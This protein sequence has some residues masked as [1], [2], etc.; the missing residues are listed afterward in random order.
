MDLFTHE[1]E[2]RS[3]PLFKKLATTKI[4]VCGCGAIGS[5][6]IDNL[7]RQGFKQI[8]VIDH[9]RIE[10]HN[11]GTQIWDFRETGKLKTETMKTRAY[12]STK[13]IV[14]SIPRKLTMDNTTKLLKD[15][16]IIIDTFDN[17][18]SRGLLYNY[19]KETN[20]NCLHTGLFQDY[21]EI[22]WNETYIVPK[23][24]K[25]MDVCEYPL[26]RNIIMLTIAVASETL[27]KF[28]YNGSKD[29]YMITLK[30]LKI[31]KKDD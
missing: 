28:I 8:T 14:N 30:N 9:D 16:D 13:T 17:T 7:I 11:R 21:G 23:E 12:N 15:A 10:D 31:L 20:T 6:L 5:N 24:T 27:I 2:Y 25:G 19:C 4:T 18:E 1:E 26:A 22:I 3:E 29:N